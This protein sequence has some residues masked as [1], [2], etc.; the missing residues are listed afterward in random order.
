MKKLK[1]LISSAVFALNINL[2]KVC[3]SIVVAI[4]STLCLRY[5]DKLTKSS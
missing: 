1:I 4:E 3:E 5:K 2:L